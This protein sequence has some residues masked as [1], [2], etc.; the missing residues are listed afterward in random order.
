[1]DL[2]E[3]DDSHSKAQSTSRQQ[4]TRVT[5]PGPI[6]FWLPGPV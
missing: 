4:Q 6:I 2:D 1:M 3:A 5:L